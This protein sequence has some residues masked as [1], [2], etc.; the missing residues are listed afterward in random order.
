MIGIHAAGE[1]ADPLREFTKPHKWSCVGQPRYITDGGYICLL[2]TQNERWQVGLHRLG[3]YAAGIAES[4]EV[5]TLD[6]KS[7]G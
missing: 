3:H 6:V 2:N 4:F 1:L 7:E 5:R